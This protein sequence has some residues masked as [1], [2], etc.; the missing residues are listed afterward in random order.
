MAVTAAEFKVRFKEFAQVADE[1]IDPKL[2]DAQA[3]TDEAAFGTADLHDRA[4]YYYAAHLLAI[5]P[6]GQQLQLVSDNGKTVYGEHYFNRILPLIGRRG[7]IS[8]GG[9]T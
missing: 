4:V 9:L 3:F 6:F 2:A 8:G 7:Q 1:D 5:S